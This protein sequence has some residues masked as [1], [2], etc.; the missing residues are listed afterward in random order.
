M[1]VVHLG[2]DLCGHIGIVHGG[3][4]ATLLDEILACV[5][6]CLIEKDGMDWLLYSPFTY[7]GSS[8]SSKIRR[9]HCQSQCR[10]PETTQSWTMGC[11]QESIESC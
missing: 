8:C 2:S 5:V 9:I 1:A 10:L 6:C 11:S 7:L 3:M 4:I